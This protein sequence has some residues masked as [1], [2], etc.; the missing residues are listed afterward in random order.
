MFLGWEGG[1]FRE[2]SSFLLKYYLN[3]VETNND[4]D[5]RNNGA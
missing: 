5:A 1:R 3:G 4:K 2:N